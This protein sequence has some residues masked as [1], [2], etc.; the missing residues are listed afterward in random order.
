M[1]PLPVVRRPPGLGDCKRS[2]RHLTGSVETSCRFLRR[3]GVVTAAPDGIPG[4]RQY[5]PSATPLRSPPPTARHH[6]ARSPPTRS[7]RDRCNT[8]D[9]CKILAEKDGA[10]STATRTPTSKATPTITSPQSK[11]PT[12]T[13]KASWVLQVSRSSRL[14]SRRSPAMVST[15]KPAP[16]RDHA[17]DRPADEPEHIADQPCQGSEAH[18][19]REQRWLAT[20]HDSGREHK[21]QAPEGQDDRS[22]VARH[23]RDEGDR[24]QCRG[25]RPGIGHQW[26]KAT[27]PRDRSGCRGTRRPSRGVRAGEGRSEEWHLPAQAQEPRPHAYQQGHHHQR[28]HGN[29]ERMSSDHRCLR[30]GDHAHDRSAP[31]SQQPPESPPLRWHM[32]C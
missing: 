7:R 1:G 32:V 27:A 17:V 31:V 13:R 14:S 21:P 5:E 11:R 25:Q 19:D 2:P 15:R 12:P 29:A 3:S 10:P 4:V 23:V 18:H 8:P 20:D 6:P 16:P 22:W 30:R 28:H 9:D 24:P 26:P